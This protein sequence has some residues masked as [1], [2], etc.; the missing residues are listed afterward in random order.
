MSTSSAAPAPTDVPRDASGAIDGD[1]LAR[2]HADAPY[3]HATITRPVLGEP[4]AHRVVV[5]AVTENGTLVYSTDPHWVS[6]LVPDADAGVSWERE[7]PADTDP[8]G[9]WVS[10]AFLD[11]DDYA[12]ARDEAED[13]DDTTQAL[14][15]HLA[16]WESGDEAD[17]AQTRD[18]AP[19]GSLDRLHP[20]TVCGVEYVLAVDDTH[21]YASLNRRPL[22]SAS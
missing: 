15:E 19:W 12:A 11:G 9:P 18:V 6:Y 7:T 8:A 3:G 14:A 20:V 5:V 4:V 2:I 21:G 17:A 10:I 22:G 1:A 16:Q 13:A